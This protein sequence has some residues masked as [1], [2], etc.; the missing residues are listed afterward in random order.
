MS[1]NGPLVLVMCSMWVLIALYSAWYADMIYGSI[2]LMINDMEI[3]DWAF[4][5]WLA[6]LFV[7]S[8]VTAGLWQVIIDERREERRRRE[9]DRRR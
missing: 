2:T 9:E 8:L 4:A 5:W 6:L 3:T 1:L 7:A